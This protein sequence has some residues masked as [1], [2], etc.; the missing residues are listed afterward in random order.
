MGLGE[1]LVISGTV[2][3]VVVVLWMKSGWI[4]TCGVGLGAGVFVFAPISCIL[5]GCLTVVL[6]LCVGIGACIVF[7]WPRLAVMIAICILLRRPGLSIA[8]TMMPVLLSVKSLIAWLTLLN[9][10]T[11]KP[12]LV[13]T[14]IR[15][16]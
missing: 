13:A 3:V 4:V 1:V 5:I 7:G 16:L 6:S 11:E 10:C 14:P 2:I 12:D 15:T 8:L 9:L